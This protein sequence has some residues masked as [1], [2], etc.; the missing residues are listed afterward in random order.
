MKEKKVY[1]KT[2]MIVYAILNLKVN[3]DLSWGIIVLTFY[4]NVFLIYINL[5]FTTLTNNEE[6]FN[7][8]FT[9]IIYNEYRL[10]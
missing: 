8:C 4:T 5:R 9:T 3:W 10:K 6:P 2:S 7:L 1:L